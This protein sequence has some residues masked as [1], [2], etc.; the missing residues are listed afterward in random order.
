MIILTTVMKA[1]MFTVHITVRLSVACVYIK[2][3]AGTL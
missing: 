1:F 3:L 2:T